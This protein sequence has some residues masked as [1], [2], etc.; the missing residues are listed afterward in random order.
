MHSRLAVGYYT[1]APVVAHM[2]VTTA[3]YEGAVKN[4]FRMYLRS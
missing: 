4:A 2:Q 3:A 1:M